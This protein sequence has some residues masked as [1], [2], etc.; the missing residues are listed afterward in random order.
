M[1]SQR[2]AEEVLA[3]ALRTGGDFAEI[4]E[5][6]R[7]NRTMEMRA[8][9]MENAQNAR[10]CGAGVRVFLG[11]NAVYAY[12]N[13]VTRQGLLACA[14][15]AAAALRNGGERRSPAQLVE[16]INTNIHPIASMPAGVESAKKI[17]LM[18]DVT[19]AAQAY[20]PEIAQVMCTL[21]NWDQNVCIANSE[22]QIG[23]ASCRERV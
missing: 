22:G 12:T 11:V 3:R 9:K 7:M 14:D 8:G 4:F 10:L 2:L 6:D 17:A 21:L 5:E 13:D 18:R 1:I 15:K 23:R 20:S 16:R 19:A